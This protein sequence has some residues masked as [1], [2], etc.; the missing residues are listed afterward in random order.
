M[1]VVP[2]VLM[3]PDMQLKLLFGLASFVNFSRAVIN[4][5]CLQNRSE[6]IYP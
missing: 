1:A 6:K 2:D 3:G 4:G 5:L